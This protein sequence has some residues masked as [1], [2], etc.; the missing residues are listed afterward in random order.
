[1]QLVII[2]YPMVAWIY[3]FAGRLWIQSSKLRATKK[4]TPYIHNKNTT[5]DA[6][7]AVESFQKGL[8]RWSYQTANLL[9][10]TTTPCHHDAPPLTSSAPIASSFSFSSPIAP[11]ST[12]RQ[13]RSSVIGHWHRYEQ[14]QQCHHQHPPSEGLDME[15]SFCYLQHQRLLQKQELPGQWKYTF[16]KGV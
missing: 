7:V 9:P 2:P 5:F 4:L 10:T 8:D 11:S 1:M 13:H 6:K 3:Y 16:V 12:A 14:Q 15:A